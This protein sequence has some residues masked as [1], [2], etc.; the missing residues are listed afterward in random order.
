MATP[1]LNSSTGAPPGSNS[2]TPATSRQQVFE[3]LVM[4][5]YSSVMFL[6]SGLLF[7]VSF[8]TSRLSRPAI[9][10]YV[11]A[12]DVLSYAPVPRRRLR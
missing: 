7:L 2:T 4:L 8:A 5:W 3:Q 9:P 1:G 11:H 12:L 6:S 10:R